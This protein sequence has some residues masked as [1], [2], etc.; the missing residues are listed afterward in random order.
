MLQEVGSF[1]F[2]FDGDKSLYPGYNGTDDCIIGIVRN[3]KLLELYSAETD[4]DE[5]QNDIMV[6][7]KRLRIEEMDWRVLEFL[8]YYLVNNIYFLSD[9]VLNYGLSVGLTCQEWVDWYKYRF[10]DCPEELK[11]YTYK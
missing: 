10:E 6:N 4:W 3:E 7:L 1:C 2:N 5:N 11:I 9:E 8:H